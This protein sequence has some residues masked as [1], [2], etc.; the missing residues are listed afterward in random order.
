MRVTNSFDGTITSKP[1]LPAFSL[2]NSSSLVA[3]RLMFTS[4]PVAFLKSPSVVSPI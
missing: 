1:G 3:N 4:T 2:A